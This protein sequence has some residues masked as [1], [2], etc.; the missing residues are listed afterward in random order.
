MNWLVHATQYGIRARGLCRC[1]TAKLSEVYFEKIVC[2]HGL[3]EIRTR[4][5]KEHKDLDRFRPSYHTFCVVV[6]IALGVEMFWKDPC[7]LLYSLGGQGYMESTS[8]VLLESYYNEVGQFPCTSTSPTA[9]RVV[10]RE[11]RC[12]HVLF[13]ILEYSTSVSSPAALGLTV[14]SSNL[15]RCD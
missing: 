7:P 13:L 11:V 8:R 4:W 9:V 12:I 3:V 10:T 1:F 5:C 6:C 15:S 2:R 14:S